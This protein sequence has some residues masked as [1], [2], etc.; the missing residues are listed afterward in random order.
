[1][2]TMKKN[3][4][5]KLKILNA[6]RE[7]LETKDFSSI[8]IAELAKKAGVTEPLIYKYFKDKKDCLYR[9][10]EEYMENYEEE[11]RL[12]AADEKTNLA[13][14][15]KLIHRHIHSYDRD[16]VIARAIIVDVRNSSDYYKSKSYYLLK[17][18]NSMV[19]DIVEDAQK[20]GEIRGD[21]KARYITRLILGSIDQFCMHEI[22]FNR[23]FSPDEVAENL[24]TL[25][26]KGIIAS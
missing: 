2:K 3:P 20:N 5:G 23:K 16:R 14:L 4:P 10:V 24:W 9:L 12:D 1:M 19:S 17:N 22:I 18:Y 15:R 13:K 21:V 7:L 26:V 8:R 25:L 6:M 11:A